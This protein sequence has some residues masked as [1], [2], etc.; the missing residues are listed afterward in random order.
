MNPSRALKTIKARLL[1]VEVI[2]SK[3]VLHPRKAIE[4]AIAETACPLYCSPLVRENNECH[5]TEQPESSHR[6]IQLELEND[7]L[8]AII[9]ILDNING[10]VLNEVLD[11]CMFRVVSYVCPDP[12]PDMSPLTYESIVITGIAP[13]EP[14]TAA[15]Y[16]DGDSTM[17][18]HYVGAKKAPPNR[19]VN[20]T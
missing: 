11:A 19:A 6:V 14:I 12:P 2:N 13:A 16:P 1:K 9:E 8:I 10:L 4:Q 15:K 5:Y 17:V 18:Y 7:W 20:G 3:N